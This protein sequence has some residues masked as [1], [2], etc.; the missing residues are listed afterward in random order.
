M[1]TTWRPHPWAVDLITAEP[2]TPLERDRLELI[3]Q[4]FREAGFDENDILRALI[5]HWSF[6]IGTLQFL[7]MTAAQQAG[8]D[9]DDV[10][11]FNLRAWVLGFGAVAAG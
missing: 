6:V 7:R 8:I 5:A 9:P 4:T 2:A 1:A 11:E 10:F 3:T